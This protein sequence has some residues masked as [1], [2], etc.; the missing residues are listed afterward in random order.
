[1]KPLFGIACMPRHGGKARHIAWH[2][3][4][5]LCLHAVGERL[6]GKGDWESRAYTLT[7]SNTFLASQSKT[8]HRTV[9]TFWHQTMI[10]PG[11]LNAAYDQQI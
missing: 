10:Q 8:K 4:K 2:H 7:M 1:M 9:A 11:C 6:L 3:V 5:L